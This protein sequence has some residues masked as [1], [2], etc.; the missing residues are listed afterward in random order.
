MRITAILRLEAVIEKLRRKRSV[1]PDDTRP[2][3]DTRRIE[4]GEVRGTRILTWRWLPRRCQALP[5]RR[6]RARSA[7][8]RLSL[9]H[10]LSDPGGAEP[11]R[12]A[13]TARARRVC[14]TSAGRGGWAVGVILA[15]LAEDHSVDGEGALEHLELPH[16]PAQR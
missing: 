12:S 16:L 3:A 13:A 6:V 2:A 15:G 8:A 10:L 1:E 11:G 9:I 14:A 7:H 5:G 4:T